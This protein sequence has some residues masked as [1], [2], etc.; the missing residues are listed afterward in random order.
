MWT[1]R[2]ANLFETSHDWA[3]TVEGVTDFFQ[4][5]L[6]QAKKLGMG[7]ETNLVLI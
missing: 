2:I 7:S 4:V 5:R 3:L 6:S 1:Q